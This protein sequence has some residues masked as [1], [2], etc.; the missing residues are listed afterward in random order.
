MNAWDASFQSRLEILSS[1]DQFSALGEGIDRDV[2]QTYW[3]DYTAWSEGVLA[4]VVRG[5]LKTD[6][7]DSG[8]TAIAGLGAFNDL[9]TEERAN[10]LSPVYPIRA[11][12]VT[13]TGAIYDGIHPIITQ[14]GLQF[15]VHT[16]SSSSRTLETR[17]R[18][19]IELTN[20]YSSALAAEDLRVVVSGLPD[21][22]DI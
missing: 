12:S 2:T 14:V 10:A 17:L 13:A 15:S 22:L 20:P 16:I 7:T 6:L 18:F 3:H 21:S 11:G 1:R 5:E 4:D 9:M 8:D 19:F